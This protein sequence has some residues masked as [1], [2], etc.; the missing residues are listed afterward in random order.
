MGGARL[1][2]LLL[3]A[4]AVPA[5]PLPPAQASPGATRTEIRD[6]RGALPAAGVPPFILTSLGLLAAGA[7][8]LTWS[9]VRRRRPLHP[10]LPPG[11]GQNPVE[12][13]RQL[14][15]AYR[16]GDFPPDILCLTLASL[17]RSAV[18]SRAGVAAHRLTTGELLD[19]LAG[20][21]LL[22]ARDLALA[23][24]LLGFCDLVKFARHQPDAVEL[25]WL[26]TAVEEL[27][28]GSWEERHEVS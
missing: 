1:A 13:V 28:D 7:L 8:T 15:A 26:L 24:E 20:L 6:L 21:R 14:G 17:V 2:L 12:T 16:R 11:T 9:G 5:A 27:L 4:A 18:S 19:R 25:Q 22:P 3:A 23:G 10:P